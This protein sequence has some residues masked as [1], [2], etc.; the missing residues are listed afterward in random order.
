MGTEVT[1]SQICQAARGD[2]TALAAVIARMLPSI[3]AEAVK[4]V[5]PGLE[6]EDAPVD[7]VRKQ[8]VKPA[9]KI[10]P[11]FEIEL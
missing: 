7:E 1:N 6:A 4:A 8:A 11:D 5:C 3:R 9:K 10:E 2:E